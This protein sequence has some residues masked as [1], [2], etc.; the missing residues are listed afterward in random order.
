MAN[1]NNLNIVIKVIDHATKKLQ[2]IDK[3]VKKLG[4][5]SEKTA[6]KAEKLGAAN[7]KRLN[8]NLI[9]KSLKDHD[10]LSVDSANKKI[11]QEKSV[12][13][14]KTAMNQQWL[15]EYN[16]GEKEHQNFLRAE[17]TSSQKFQKAIDAA[18]FKQVEASRKKEIQQ[19]KKQEAA[20]LAFKRAMNQ[21]Q[22]KEYNQQ[23]KEKER[24]RKKHQKE[25]DQQNK[26]QQRSEK[27]SNVRGVKQAEFDFTAFN[28][29]LFTTMA[30]VG[31]FTKLFGALGNRLEE[32]ANLERL[33]NQFSRVFG[34][35][36]TIGSEISKFTTTSVDEMVAMQ[37]ALNMGNAG[38]VQ[39]QTQ[40]AEII[41]KAATASKMANI[42]TAT[43][44]HEVTEA[45]KSG[46]LANLE[47]L[48]IIKTNDPALKQRMHLLEKYSGIMSPA[49]I[50]Q[51]KYNIILQALTRHT[52]DEMFAARDLSDVITIVGSKFKILSGT[53]GSF[54]GKAV[55]PLV[56][57]L[58]MLVDKF[59]VFLEQAKQNKTLVE[60]T[61]NLMVVGSTI[62]AIVAVLGTLRLGMM[63]FG[64]V[65]L[66]GFGGLLA[67]VGG[68]SLALSNM[69]EPIE[70]L[71]QI[72]TTVGAV[73]SGIFQMVSSFF[74]DSENYNN[75]VMKMK[76]STADFLSSVKIG[77]TDLRTIVENISR[78]TIVVVK[79]LMDMGEKIEK[80]ITN[81]SNSPFFKA[82]SDKFLGEAGAWS[83]I[84]L[85]ETNTVRDGM[86]EA[87][88]IIAAAWTA[89]AL[90]PELGG[91]TSL[92]IGGATTA[93]LGYVGMKTSLKKSGEEE[94]FF[95]SVEDR[96]KNIG[97]KKTRIE[98][99][100]S[101]AL[102]EKQKL[103]DSPIESGLLEFFSMGMSKKDEAK[104][105]MS[106]LDQTI[107]ALDKQMEDTIKIEKD[108]L[109]AQKELTKSINALV[110]VNTSLTTNAQ[111]VADTQA[112][113]PL[114]GQ[115]TTVPG[116]SVLPGGGIGI[117]HVPENIPAIDFAG[118]Y[119]KMIE[120]SKKYANAEQELIFRKGMEAALANERE[121]EGKNV[122]TREELIEIYTMAINKS[123]VAENTKPKNVPKNKTK[124]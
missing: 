60:F 18:K 84:W 122:I 89:K 55:A 31:T 63:L 113:D 13:L 95:G 1:N 98:E 37:E 119:E 85:D 104:L 106:E 77:N 38:I 57:K 66:G 32:G 45:L 82:I 22:L 35:S 62:T 15:K 8:N 108:L 47:H 83:K 71:T 120:T 101:S 99:Q 94:G 19:E 44:I 67:V 111:N 17:A 78:G 49:V 43:G 109:D 11:K 52:K 105:G 3:L 121:K 103:L 48:N 64:G 102:V 76:K 30:F 50:A 53:V 10:R 68:I 51:E 118:S 39:N 34:T 117:T 100:K 115:F 20:V 56:I 90:L 21:Q 124:C 93:A 86:V 97:K 12:L 80:V 116:G 75:R 72:A 6:E 23:E 112:F 61:K 110:Q 79:F 46:S 74:L 16:K 54:L 4:N 42:D 26:I 73:F 29:T 24:L 65:G 87:A 36:G 33:Q 88:A 81:I 114:T 25:E 9:F 58:G 14:H 7:L 107:L 40:A 91:I 28:R 59:S 96:L 2:D 123:K 41:A 70:A 5:T 92:L 27:I 69:Q